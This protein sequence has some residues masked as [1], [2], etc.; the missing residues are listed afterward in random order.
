MER[1]QVDYPF[2][3][4]HAN[5]TTFEQLELIS[6]R[7]NLVALCNYFLLFIHWFYGGCAPRTYAA[8]DEVLDLIGD[9]ELRKAQLKHEIPDVIQ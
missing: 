1:R 8:M 9:I 4:P 6:T 2:D 3:E 5:L 7:E